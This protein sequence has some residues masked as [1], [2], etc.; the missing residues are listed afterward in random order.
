M[1]NWISVLLALAAGAAGA[2]GFS[3]IAAGGAPRGDR[4]AADGNSAELAEAMRALAREIQ[5]L[6]LAQNAS[7]SGPPSPSSPREPAP[8]SNKSAPA[9]AAAALDRLLA[10]IN[11][12]SALS[13]GAPA[14]RAPKP[15]TNQEIAEIRE[16]FNKVENQFITKEH[17]FLTYQQI[18]DR[19]G[20]PNEIH[21]NNDGQS[22]EY[23]TSS[24]EKGPEYAFTVVFHDGFV[25]RVDY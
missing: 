14:L 16:R 5:S 3:A 2:A 21:S 10:K 8:Q 13:A 12:P 19:Y 9:D 6:R 25:I 22:W 15:L 24:S 18:L 4:L 1:K 17:F 7:A 20:P 11:N 23:A